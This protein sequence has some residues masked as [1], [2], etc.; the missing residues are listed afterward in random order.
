MLKKFNNMKIRKK[1]TNGFVL[2]V[3][4]ASVAAIVAC[5]AMIFKVGRYKYALQIMDFLRGILERH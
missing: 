4:I 2:V 5:I 3:S 1:I